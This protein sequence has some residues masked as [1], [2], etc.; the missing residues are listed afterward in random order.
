MIQDIYFKNSKELAKKIQNGEI[1][2]WIAI[3]NFI[4]YSA[5][6]ASYAIPVTFE[7]NQDD[8]FTFTSNILHFAI[9]AI[10]QVWGFRLLYNTNQKGDGKDFFFR[11]CAL[12]LPI[13]IQVFASAIAA[14]C[15]LVIAANL[16]PG[17]FNKKIDLLPQL[18]YII[19]VF[20]SLYQIIF[21][22][23]MQKNLI[24]C[25]KSPA[26]QAGTPLSGA[27]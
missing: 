24:S 23:L 25:S 2:E 12:S 6:M 19:I 17:S 4:F 22:K 11:Y 1:S 5:F 21:F 27:P 9:L 15:I 8:T 10:I 16:L 20:S 7:C 13:S 3:K 18:A 26:S 14:I